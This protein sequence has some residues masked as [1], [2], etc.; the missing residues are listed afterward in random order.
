M[1]PAPGFGAGGNGVQMALR[2]DQWVWV[3]THLSL[4][5]AEQSGERLRGDDWIVDQ[6]ARVP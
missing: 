2:T 6:T 1:L 3:R 4:A 5:A